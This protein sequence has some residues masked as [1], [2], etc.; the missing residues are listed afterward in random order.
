MELKEHWGCWCC[1]TSVWHQVAYSLKP[2]WA[3]HGAGRNQT[4]WFSG[5]KTPISSHTWFYLQ[6]IISKVFIRWHFSM[7]NLH[8]FSNCEHEIWWI[9]RAARSVQVQNQVPGWRLKPWLGL[10]RA[11]PPN[12]RA[13]TPTISGTNRWSG[14][15][16]SHAHPPC[17]RRGEGSIFLPANRLLRIASLLDARQRRDPTSSFSNRK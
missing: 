15:G 14:E 8:L 12:Y 2:C 13:V 7:E 5:P 6:T 3:R 4:L 9:Q 16:G 11:Q 10:Q 17:R 1:F